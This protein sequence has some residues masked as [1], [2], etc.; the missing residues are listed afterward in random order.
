MKIIDVRVEDRENPM[1]LDIKNPSIS[2]KIK[3]NVTNFHQAAYQVIVYD[4]GSDKV[5]WDSGKVESDQSNFIKYKG[6]RLKE[7]TRYEFKIRIWNDKEEVS[8]W[9]PIHYWETGILKEET[10][11]AKWITLKG[12][13]HDSPNPYF[14]KSFTLNGRIKQAIV[15]ATSLGLY[16]LY[17]NGN[18]IGND[19]LAPGWTN[20]NKWVQYQTYDVTEQLNEQDNAI[21]F[22]VGN[23]WF[24]GGLNPFRG[25]KHNIYGESVAAFAQLHV[26]FDDGTEAVICTDETWTSTTGPILYSDLYNGESYDATKELGD[27]SSPHYNECRWSPVTVLNTTRN[28]VA[29]IGNPVRV[30]E[31]IKPK[32][33][34]TTP[35]GETVLDMGQNMVGWIRFKIRGMKGEQVTLKHGEVL[36]PE[37]DFYTENLREAKQTIR[38]TCKGNGQEVYEPRFSFQ[39]FRY[40]KLENFPLDITIDNFEGIVIGSTTEKIGHFESSNSLVNQLQSNITWSQKGNFIDVPTDCPQRDERLGW[41]GDVAMFSSTAAFNFNVL[42]FF[43]KWLIDVKQEQKELNGAVPIIIPNI[44]GPDAGGMAG[45][46]DASII[47]PW[48]MYL[49]YG[50]QT[51]LEDQYDSMKQWLNYV[52]SKMSDDALWVQEFQ[53][54]DWLALDGD[55]N[56]RKGG[57]DETFVA[58]AFFVNSLSIFIKIAK[59]LEQS[60]DVNYF[61]DIKQKVIRGLQINYFNESG[62]LQIN[63]QTAHVLTLVFDICTEEK[64]VN[65]IEQLVNLLK[66]NNYHLTTGFLGTPYLCQA[67]SENGYT[68]VAYRLLLNEQYPSWLY[69]V[70]KGATTIWERWNGIQEDGSLFNPRMNS[71][72]HYAY[73]AIGNWLYNE[74]AGIKTDESKPG[75]KRIIINPKIDRKLKFVKANLMSPHG[76]IRSEWKVEEDNIL[77]DIEVPP[78]TTASIV[79]DDAVE[80]SIKINGHK[81]PSIVEVGSG[82]YHIEFVIDCG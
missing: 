2:W 48:N 15:Y 77:L 36:D 13:Q 58:N 18:R 76:L 8:N 53:L 63:T 42:S 66:N 14:R 56:E 51:I 25:I 17:I 24:R 10:W 7:R 70:K 43:K 9:S 12:N 78:N 32:E 57:T 45:W 39:G 29:Q 21:G 54:G 55:P 20:Y 65:V 49:S 1:G 50:D 23:G 67:L 52:V 44:L 75:Y 40:V 28:F 4:K 37:G 26:T 80:D 73:G 47:C 64:R 34:I 16:E 27:W 71:F 72:N 68:D 38:Y 5:V 60:D 81:S 19:L 61:E 31:V 35:K 6:E 69:Q 79:L 41:T 74:V 62:I 22:V 82:K 30:L 11:Q 33:I 3:T 59:L 46:S